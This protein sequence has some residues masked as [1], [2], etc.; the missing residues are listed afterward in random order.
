MGGGGGMGG[1]GGRGDGDGT[2]EAARVGQAPH[3]AIPLRRLDG[4][5][6]CVVRG[7]RVQDMKYGG[8][9]VWGKNCMGV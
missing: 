4:N 1:E 2:C 6:G 3:S 5:M 8:M 7:M 9:M